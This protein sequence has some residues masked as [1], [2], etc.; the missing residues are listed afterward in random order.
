MRS[1]FGLASYRP[2]QEAVIRS[3]VKGHDTIAIMPTG[4]GKS[5]CYQLP[6]LHLPGTTV[7]VSPLIALMKDQAD[8]LVELGAKAVQVNSTFTDR[9]IGET[10]DSIRRGATEFVFATPERLEDPSFVAALKAANVDVFVVDE[11]HC[12]SQWGHDFR[13]AYLGLGSAIT[14]LGSPPVLALTATATAP[15]IDD[16]VRQL[17]LDDARV[18]TLGVYRPNLRYSVRHTAKELAKQQHLVRLL[19]ETSGTG[20][21]YV[22]TV[23]HCDEVARVLE[24][25]GLAVAQY[26]GRLSPASRRDAQDRFMRGELKAIVATNA[27]GMGIDKPDIRFVVHYDVP[28][29]LEAYYQES[30]RAGRDG[31]PADCVLLYRLEDRRT[32]QYFMGGKYARAEDILG[33]REALRALGAADAPVALQA[34]Q[35][36]AAGVA[37]TRVRSVLAT[38]KDL[39]IVKELRASRFRLTG[40]EI[41]TAAIEDVAR[42]YANRQA[43]DRDKLERMTSYAQ[44]ASCRWKLL[45]EYF[46]EAGDFDRCGT[47]DN[48]MDPP[49]ARFAPPRTND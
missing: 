16:I 26:H 30:G 12:L 11:A 19:R 2:G 27:F 48:C 3:I 21:V 1:T 45:L 17:G 24:A 46:G 31:E 23:R 20:I 37:R 49:E 13:P 36:S 33:V 5:L 22:A 15:V 32:H 10:I 47:C 29:S 4:A 34:V 25:E 41:D 8:K 14:A 40:A 9:E 7:V 35:E 39:G 18:F 43:A 42:Q 38:M 28:G 6:A 44:S